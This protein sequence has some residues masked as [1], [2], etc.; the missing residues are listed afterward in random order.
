MNESDKTA[1][2]KLIDDAL[3][4]HAAEVGRRVHE[5]LAPELKMLL[6]HIMEVS[7]HVLDLEEGI[8]RRRGG[9]P[10]SINGGVP[11]NRVPMR[12]RVLRAIRSSGEHGV[13][14][15]YLGTILQRT[16]SDERRSAISALEAEGLI[17]SDWS[18]DGSLKRLYRMAKP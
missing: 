17:V 2:R 14:L 5:A 7:A 6:Q 13:S 15:G 10:P 12:D 9:R 4:E 3:A 1:L 16:T 18:R 8:K 11:G